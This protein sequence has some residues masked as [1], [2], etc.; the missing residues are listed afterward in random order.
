MGLSLIIPCKPIRDLTC[1][2]KSRREF[3]RILR[4]TP[5][6]RWSEGRNS[7]YIHSDQGMLSGTYRDRIAADCLHRQFTKLPVSLKTAFLFNPHIAPGSGMLGQSGKAGCVIVRRA[8]VVTMGEAEIGKGPVDLDPAER[9]AQRW[10]TLDHRA[11]RATRSGME[12]GSRKMR[13]QIVPKT[14]QDKLQ[15]RS[16]SVLPAQGVVSKQYTLCSRSA[17]CNMRVKDPCAPQ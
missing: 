1:G 14:G 6:G 2:A 5:W 4:E 15:S 3:S 13:S 11:Q 7:L 9:V 17:W 8:I 10:A 16:P 12:G